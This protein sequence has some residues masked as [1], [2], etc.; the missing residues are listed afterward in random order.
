MVTSANNDGDVP[1]SWKQIVKIQPKLQNLQSKFLP[2][3]LSDDEL[4][5]IDK[6]RDGIT[7]Q[8]FIEL[9]Y[10]E[11]ETFLDVYASADKPISDGIF[12]MMP[13]DL[14]NKYIGMS[15]GLSDKQY[16]SI[17]S[18]PNLLKRYTQLVKR[19]FEIWLEDS[20]S[21][22][23]ANSEL[24]VLDKYNIWDTYIDK[25]TS[26]NIE[27]L[28]S[29]S[30]DPQKT[31]DV[32]LN[33]N[34][35]LTSD[36]ANILLV[37]SDDPQKTVDVLL[38]KNVPLTDAY[39]SNLLTFST[40]KQTTIDFLLS[41]GL[42]IDKILTF[43]YVNNLLLYSTDKQT[44]INLLFNNNVPLTDPNV[45]R[46]LLNYSPSKEKTR[47]KIDALKLKQQLREIKF[48]YRDFFIESMTDSYRYSANFETESI[49]YED[50][51]TG[52]VYKKDVLQPVQIVRFTGGDGTPYI[53]YVKRDH[54]NDT[55][56]TI[57]FGIFTGIDVRGSNKLDINL[58]N[59][60]DAFRVLSTVINITND[61]IQFDDDYNEVQRLMFTS[62]G[63][64]RTALYLKRVV[65]RIENFKVDNVSSS[66]SET[67]VTLS[68]TY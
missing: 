25:L 57:A 3:P 7:T 41:K 2:K 22:K 49:D 51:D 63:D 39:V 65:P 35:Q 32:L 20:D 42:S 67:T 11:K 64:K 21:K 50:E 61:F 26:D 56:W 53:W 34:V 46:L 36:N 31:I 43:R 40:D 37:Y 5:V 23:F 9:S 68:R 59:K 14:K 4:D 54:Y 12:E 27:N 58:S 66:G 44:T 6:Y 52:E 24:D 62:E 60:G 47:K 17:Q 15:I 28:L 1:M 10:N 16:K 45:I 13:Y 38:N 30:T 33:K 18:D 48:K 55:L 29:Y 19:K 8:E